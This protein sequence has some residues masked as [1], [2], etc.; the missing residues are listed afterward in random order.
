MRPADAVG[1]GRPC[2]TTNGRQW[3]PARPVPGVQAETRCPDCQATIRADEAHRDALGL[4]RDVER[5]LFP[6]SHTARRRSR[7][8]SRPF[9]AR[10][11]AASLAQHMIDR[12]SHGGQP[13]RNLAFGRARRNP[14]EIP[15]G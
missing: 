2:I 13:P 14:S 6:S 4:A 12:G 15:R 10:K 1:I 9:T 7:C 8:T 3:C 5:D 11:S